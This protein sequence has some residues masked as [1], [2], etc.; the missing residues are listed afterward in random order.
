[1]PSARVSRRDKRFDA[2]A[3]VMDSPHRQAHLVEGRVL[4]IRLQPEPVELG[5]EL[6]LEQ[7]SDLGHPGLDRVLV[8]VRKRLPASRYL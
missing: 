5:R 2:V 1:M 6:V 4:A 7:A 3:H 8:L